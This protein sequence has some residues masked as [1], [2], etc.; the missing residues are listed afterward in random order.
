LEQVGL[1]RA[2][3]QRLD[4]VER[5]AGIVVHFEVTGTA[6]EL[7]PHV[8]EALYH[9]AQ[10]ALN[11]ALKHAAASEVMIALHCQGPLVA[12]TVG[13]NGSGFDPQLVGDGGMGLTSMKERVQS[14]NGELRVESQPGQG[15]CIT[16][17]LDLQRA[18][19]SAALHDV[20]DLL[21]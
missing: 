17:E 19:E 2:L 11:N 12:L 4:A 13:D 3:R 5:R 16:A 20:L 8:E 10:E 14:L 21:V 9:I 1:I 6:P 7:P 18:G 15:T